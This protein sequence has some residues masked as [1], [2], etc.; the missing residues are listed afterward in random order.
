MDYYGPNAKNNRNNN[1]KIF[2]YMLL[3]T[4][5]LLQ[6]GLAALLIRFVIPTTTDPKGK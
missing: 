5:I 6:I 3:G 2:K 4:L 1:I